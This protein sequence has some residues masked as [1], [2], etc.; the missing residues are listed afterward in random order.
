M[1]DAQISGPWI[2]GKAGTALEGKYVMGEDLEKGYQYKT[3][4]TE[5]V[6]PQGL[7]GYDPDASNRVSLVSPQDNPHI[8]FSEYPAHD[9]CKSI[10]GR[11]P[12]WAELDAIR[13]D[14]VFYGNNVG[15]WYYVSASNQIEGAYIMSM[16]DGSAFSV[17]KTVVLSVRCVA[18]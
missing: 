2:A 1:T 15:E 7:L 14:K 13:I 11:L 9:A 6:A 10:G 12:F 3:S 5:L 17:N 4:N 18:G 16:A 8:D